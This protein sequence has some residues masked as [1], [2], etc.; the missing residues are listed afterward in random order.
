MQLKSAKLIEDIRD[1][2]AFILE[3]TEGLTAGTFSSNRLVRQAV[4]RNF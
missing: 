2:A 4:E 3:A 1:A